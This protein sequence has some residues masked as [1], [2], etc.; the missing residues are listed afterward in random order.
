MSRLVEN[1]LKLRDKMCGDGL[2]RHASVEACIACMAENY[3]GG[4][5]GGGYDL[6]IDHTTRTL[7]Y[8]DFEA[9]RD[10]MF[11]GIPP[12][13]GVFEYY[14]DDHA[15]DNEKRF[16]SKKEIDGV[17]YFKMGGSTFDTPSITVGLVTDGDGVGYHL[18]E[19]NVLQFYQD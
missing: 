15:P 18:L 17:A 2:P 7:M 19:G 8:G 14:E 16:N 9:I 12:I 10:K 5:S 11:K 6:V 13:V 3:A 1:L 4:G